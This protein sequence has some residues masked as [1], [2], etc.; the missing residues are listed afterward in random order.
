MDMI[1]DETEPSNAPKGR[2]KYYGQDGKWHTDD[3]INVSRI[4]S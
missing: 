3:T 2:W 1:G 4:T